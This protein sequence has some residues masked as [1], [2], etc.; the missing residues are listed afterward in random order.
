MT[1]DAEAMKS[2][3]Q[4]SENVAAGH[5]DIRAIINR[6]YEDPNFRGAMA[7]LAGNPKPIKV[8]TGCWF[9]L[10]T[11]EEVETHECPVQP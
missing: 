6:L 10:R 5:E 4:N 1:H 3:P 11:A 8:C 9:E 2:G 7:L